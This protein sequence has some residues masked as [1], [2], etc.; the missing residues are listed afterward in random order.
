MISE[1]GTKVAEYFSKEVIFAASKCNM[2]NPY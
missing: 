1:E 2:K